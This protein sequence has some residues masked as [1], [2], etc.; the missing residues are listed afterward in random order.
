MNNINVNYPYFDFN[1]PRQMFNP[2]MNPQMN[3]Q[4]NHQMNPQ[5]NPQMN[6]QM[7]PQIN[8]QINFLN[9]QMPNNNFAQNQYIIPPRNQNIRNYPKY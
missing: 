3:F 2:Q 7:K 5:M 9:P 4:M 1:R 8:P 6:R